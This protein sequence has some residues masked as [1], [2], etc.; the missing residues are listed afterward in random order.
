MKASYSN[1]GGSFDTQAVE[2]AKLEKVRQLIAANQVKECFDFLQ[3]LA[4][5]DA[6]DKNTVT[7]L[8]SQYAA[9]MENQAKNLIAN[10]DFQA[11]L[12]S[13]KDR[14]LTLSPSIYEKTNPTT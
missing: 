10:D 7:L 14:I 12:N 2:T 9:L 4:A 8:K 1:R 13:L 6:E 5:N 3:E 11:E